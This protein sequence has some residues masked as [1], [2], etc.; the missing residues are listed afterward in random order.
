MKSIL[1]IAL[2]IIAALG[3]FLD[4][5]RRALLPRLRGPAQRC[6]GIPWEA[7]VEV[8]SERIVVRA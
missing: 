8:R 2:G 6:R 5:G 1:K 4:I 3:G 7:V